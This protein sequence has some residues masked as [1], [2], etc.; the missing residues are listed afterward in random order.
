MPVADAIVDED[1]VPGAQW[2]DRVEVDPLG[3]PVD[4]C[5]KVGLRVVVDVP[6][7]VAGVPSVYGERTAEPV[8]VRRRLGGVTREKLAQV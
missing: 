8:D 5:M 2:S 6:R 4:L 3:P 1:L 7:E